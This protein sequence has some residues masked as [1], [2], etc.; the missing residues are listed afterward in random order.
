[1]SSPCSRRSAADWPSRTGPSRTGPSRTG[2]SRTGP[3]RTGPSRTGPSRTGPSPAAGRAQR[4][5]DRQGPHA[6]A[7]VGAG[8]LAG[9]GRVAGDVDHVVGQLP[10]HADLLAG[11][12]D[13]RHH[14]GRSTGEHGA[15][16]PGGGDQRSGLLGDDVHVVI[17][18]VLAGPRPD[19]LGQLPLDQPAERLGLDPDRVRAEVGQD[20][21]R[22]REQEVTGQD[23]DRVAPPGVDRGTAAADLGLVHDVVVEQRGQV[24]QLDSHRRLDDPR[25]PGVA[26]LR[27]QQHQQGPEPLAARRD[28]MPG[29][30]GE[31]L[32][33]GM[34][35]LHER[36]LDPGQIV[37]NLRRQGGV[38]EIYRNCGDHILSRSSARANASSFRVC[39]ICPG[40]QVLAQGWT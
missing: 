2:P 30:L 11:H 8:G 4:V 39:L 19:G 20:T 23:G 7:Q 12:R 24:G 6:L 16:L 25:V 26:E 17:E 33:I 1:M 40:G 22:L 18:R 9:L 3:S 13:P 32:V 28:G 31:E 38:R 10:G 36:R 14:L 5:Q 35:R 34:R 21:G 29:S 27:G 15:E 37:K